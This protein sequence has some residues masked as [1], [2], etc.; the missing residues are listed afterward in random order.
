MA[1]MTRGRCTEGIPGEDVAAYYRRRAEGE[2]GLIITEGVGIRRSGSLNDPG[3]PHLYGEKAVAGWRRV[4]A[5]VHEA[6]GS[7]AAQLWHVGAR[8]REGVGTP[9]LGLPESPSGLAWPG[10]HVGVAMDEAMIAEV[11][12]AYAEAAAN[13]IDAGFD[14]VEIHAAHGYLIDQFFW[15]A[16]NLRTD[17]WGGETL[18]ERSRFAVEV[19][20]AVRKAI[21]PETALII[22]VSQNKSPDGSIRLA[23]SPQEMES[24]L[25]PLV[26]A[27]ADILHCSGLEHWATQFE[28]SDLGFAGWAKRVAGVPTIT[29]GSIGLERPQDA[30]E[31]AIPTVSIDTVEQRLERNEFDL[32][33][34]GRA[35]ITNPDWPRKIAPFDQNILMSTLV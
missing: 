9:P 14:A 28:E 6:G 1:P 32:V 24:W 21:G 34:V 33:A 12:E 29:V 27:G 7:I 4:V 26:E 16:T 19:L 17:R 3:C 22:R 25:C 5:E 31:G 18:A 2:V 23:N 15:D 20:R 13:A 8:P 10:K 35:L 11:I 30:T